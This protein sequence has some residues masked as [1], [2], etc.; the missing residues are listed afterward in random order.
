MIVVDTSAIVAIVRHE[1]EELIFTDILD[2]SSAAI[3]SAV[4]FVEAHMV[5]I[6]R[7]LRAD[8]EAVEKTMTALGIDIVEVS[9]DQIG[10]AIGGFLTYGKGRNPA[11]L[12]LADCFAYAL[13]KSRGVPLL[14]KGDDFPQT[15]IIPA[16]RP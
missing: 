3:M 9:H 7:R 6:G 14:F 8:L 2:S 1:P 11:H 16:W 13:A 12:N 5:L 10:L 4:S 15:D